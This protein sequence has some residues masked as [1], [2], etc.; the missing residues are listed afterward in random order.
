MIP[1]FI[2]YPSWDLVGGHERIL[3]QLMGVNLW[4]LPSRRWCFWL[5]V[6]MSATDSW[7]RSFHLGVDGYKDVLQ[8]VSAVLARL[9]NGLPE[10]EAVARRASR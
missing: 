9:H 7:Y 6:W 10:D 5:L 2:I 4:H 1:S 3:Q 8:Q